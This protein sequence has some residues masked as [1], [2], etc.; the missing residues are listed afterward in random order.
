MILATFPCCG[1]HGKI[2]NVSRSGYRYISDSSILT[3]P[4]ID[5]PSNIHLL[6]NAF[7]SC[8]AVIATFFNV[9][10]IS[11]NCSLINSIS[12]SSTILIMSCFVYL[13]ILILL[14]KILLPYYNPCCLRKYQAHFRS[15]HSAG[16]FQV[17]LTGT[18]L[19]SFLPRLHK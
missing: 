15:L 1:L 19:Q 14:H 2:I 8:P 4:S 5:D 12:S 9:P 17:P 13:L 3:N 7:S 10:N 16:S 11:V 6:S 18:D